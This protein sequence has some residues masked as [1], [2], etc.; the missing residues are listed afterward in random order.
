MRSKG[1]VSSVNFFH[2]RGLLYKSC[3]KN[4]SYCLDIKGLLCEKVSKK[5]T[6]A[7]TSNGYWVRMQIADIFP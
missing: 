1:K 2:I 7:L 5:Q 3:Q 6:A 4:E